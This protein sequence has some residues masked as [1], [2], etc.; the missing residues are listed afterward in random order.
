MTQKLNYLTYK[1][2]LKTEI[3]TAEL[4]N[5]YSGAD[6]KLSK[7]FLYKFDKAT[8]LWIDTTDDFIIF[9]ISQWILNKQIEYTNELNQQLEM[10]PSETQD[11]FKQIS[12]MAK[13]TPKITCFSHLTRVYKFLTK[14]IN[15]DEF[16]TKLNHEFPLFLPIKNGL[17]VDLTTSITSPRE[18]HH[19][20]SYECP[21]EITTKKTNFLTIL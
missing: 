3:T 17:V 11:I 14:L 12:T 16:V 1:I 18:K 6:Y 20:F 19:L 2:A 13:D 10:N 21:V 7:R 5:A 15:D 8:K 4:F 9:D